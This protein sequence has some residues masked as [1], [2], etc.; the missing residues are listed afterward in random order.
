MRNCGSPKATY[1][2]PLSQHSLTALLKRRAINKICKIT[3]EPLLLRRGEPP[4]GGGEVF[5]SVSEADT[6]ISHS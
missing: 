5:K 2:K 6:L 4:L 1:L 3:I